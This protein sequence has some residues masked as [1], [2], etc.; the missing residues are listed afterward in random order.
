MESLSSYWCLDDSYDTQFYPSVGGFTGVTGGFLQFFSLY[1]SVQFSPLFVQS[2]L[3]VELAH[4]GDEFT[5][6]I[7]FVPPPMESMSVGSRADWHS[8][9]CAS[10]GR[11]SINAAIRFSFAFIRFII[12]L[13]LV[14]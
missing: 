13:I 12:R 5:H 2:S 8:P 14:T 1:A 10:I 3:F 6:V 9:N 11:L 7:T 4:D